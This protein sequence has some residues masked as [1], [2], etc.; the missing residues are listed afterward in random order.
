MANVREGTLYVQEDIKRGINF[1][2]A[3]FDN[4]QIRIREKN[5]GPERQR[6][7]DWIAFRKWADD[8]HHGR[9]A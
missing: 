2:V 9:T 7:N 8:F 5:D 1:M 4:G 6:F 3:E